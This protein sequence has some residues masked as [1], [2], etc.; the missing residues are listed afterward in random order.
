MLTYG[1]LV[2][3]YDLQVNCVHVWSI[4]FDWFVGREGKGGR[5]SEGSVRGLIRRLIK[6]VGGLGGEV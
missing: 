1:V 4:F 5:R 6:E 2:P 3:R